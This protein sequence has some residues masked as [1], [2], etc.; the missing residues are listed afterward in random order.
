MKRLNNLYDR[1]CQLDNIELADDKARKGKRNRPEIIKH[2]YNREQENARLLYQLQ[3]LQYR[4]S[5]YTKFKIYE[6]KERLI[7][8]LPYYPDRIVHHS[9]M[10]I[11]ED[12]WTKVF[13]HHTYSCIKGRGIH[14]IVRDLK[15]LLIRDQL[16]TQYCLKLDIKK[17]YPSIKHSVLK[18]ILRRKIKDVQLLSVLDEIV[19][20]TEGV[21]IGNYLSQFFA[22]LTLSYFDHW[23]FEEVK[24]QLKK[25]GVS[26]YYFR[27]CDDIVMLSNDKESLRYV[28]ILVKMYL[29]HILQLDIKDNYQVFPVNS[30]GIDFV[31]YVFYHDHI[32]LRKSLKLRICKLLTKYSQGKISSQQFDSRMSSY[33]GWLKYSDSKNFLQQDAFN[34]RGTHYSN[35]NGLKGKMSV[36][37]CKNVKIIEVIPHNNY[38][39]IHYIYNGKPFTVNS[40][41]KKLYTYLSC[42][43][44]PT[45][46]KFKTS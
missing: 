7:F 35:W 31:G 13:I 26:L 11:M 20:S 9:I 44:K 18:D 12:I 28:L 1:I 25:K 21:P 46:F 27:Y 8:K 3:N 32:L 41:N 14:G 17:F 43:L 37:Y 4:T 40:K 16:G 5:K 45:T 15:K 33:F 22:N 38:F 23:I 42:Y 6:P 29:H 24:T 34:V 30:R 39:S 10:N 36:I 2:D 19:D